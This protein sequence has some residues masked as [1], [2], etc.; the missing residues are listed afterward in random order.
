MHEIGF[1]LDLTLG[2]DVVVRER[3]L[4]VSTIQPYLLWL[5]KLRG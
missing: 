1:V 5:I 4:V 3:I 2:E